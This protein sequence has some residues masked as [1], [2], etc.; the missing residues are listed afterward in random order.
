MSFNLKVTE[1]LE[2]TLCVDDLNAAERF[3]REVLGLEFYAK[4][5]GRHVFFR[6]GDSMFLLF[7]ADETIKPTAPISTHGY[8]GSSHV[9]FLMDDESVDEW[10]NH[11]E[12]HSVEIE[13]EVDWPT[14]GHSIYF[15]D[16]SGNSLELATRKTW[17]WE[18]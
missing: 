6:C 7:N 9:A 13:S 16:P 12:K 11:L 10:R 14:G 15:R 3:Y 2:T 8:T 5:E 17:K 4:H 1:I 18:E